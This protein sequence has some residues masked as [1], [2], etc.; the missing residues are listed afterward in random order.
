MKIQRELSHINYKWA[1]KL[2]NREN[3]K[4]IYEKTK[5]QKKLSQTGKTKPKPS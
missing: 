5:T 1:K 2:K 4:K 3:W